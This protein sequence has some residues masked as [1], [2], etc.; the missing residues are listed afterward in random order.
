M[1]SRLEGKVAIITGTGG[2]QGRAAAQ[3]FAAEG[4]A[5]VGCDWNSEG[6]LETI[7][8]VR[9][10]GGTIAGMAPVDLGDPDQARTWVD[11]AAR[12]HGRID[13]VYN[14]ASA[15]RFAPIAELTVD[16]W[17]FTI[18]NELDLVFYVT[19]F[20][21]PHL[22]EAGGGVVINTASVSGWLGSGP[23]V[24]AHCATKGGVLAMTRAIAAEGAPYGIRAVSIS[25]GPIETPGTREMFSDPAVR[26]VMEGFLLTDRLGQ[27]SDVAAVATFLA[28]AEASFIT[29]ADYAV[30]GGMRSI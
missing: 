23:G 15:P 11:E 3:R 26:A 18:R 25:P 8:L 6:N 7:A 28:S 16:D 24:A 21:W 20:A 4:A 14:N 27:P 30:D 19:K 10:A 13:I 2:G 9:D 12:V 22:V 17:Q 1:G 29:G 5:V